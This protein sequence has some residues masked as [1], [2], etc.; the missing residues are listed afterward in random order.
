M[1]RHL[2]ARAPWWSRPKA[3]EG[4]PLQCYKFRQVPVQ[5]ESMF[6]CSS[7]GLFIIS[8]LVII[9]RNQ[10]VGRCHSPQQ[11]WCSTIQASH[12]VDELLQPSR[13]S[14]GLAHSEAMS[15]KRSQEGSLM[16]CYHSTHRRSY[17]R[18]RQQQ[19]CQ[20]LLQRGPMQGRTHCQTLFRS[21]PRHV[22]PVTIPPCSQLGGK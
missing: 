18:N 15:I 21:S 3:C 10:Q 6:L 11:F 13:V 14:T 22:P 16:R 4:R 2:D 7:M 20:S 19:Q 17:S 9:I 12:R 5:E 1:P 8:S